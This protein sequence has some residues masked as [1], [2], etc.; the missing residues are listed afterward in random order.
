MRAGDGD[1]R[2]GRDDVQLGPA[3]GGIL[4]IASTHPPPANSWAIF[5]E[6]DILPLNY[7]RKAFPIYKN[8]I[9]FQTIQAEGFLHHGMSQAEG[10]LLLRY[11]E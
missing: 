5:E 1:S 10:N 2:L 6:A 11:E 7:S 3:S 4:K 8:E 9:R